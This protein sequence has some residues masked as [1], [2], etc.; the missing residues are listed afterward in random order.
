MVGSV[1]GGQ[2]GAAV[3]TAH[4]I[5]GTSVPNESAFTWAF[6]LAAGAAF[7]AAAIALSI[8]RRPLPRGALAGG[9]AGTPPQA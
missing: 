9:L 6:G 7:I 1:V 3:L 8:A 2:L 5:P 4:T